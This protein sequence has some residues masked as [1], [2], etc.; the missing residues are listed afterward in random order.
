MSGQQVI[1]TSTWTRITGTNIEVIHA[2]E[3]NVAVTVRDGDTDPYLPSVAGGWRVRV[4]HGPV[5]HADSH[6]AAIAHLGFP[7][8]PAQL[9]ALLFLDSDGTLV[10]L[11][12]RQHGFPVT[13]DRRRALIAAL[14]NVALDRHNSDKDTEED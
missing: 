10:E 3:G 5:G 8:T 13:G 7:V 2:A 14:L 4:A 9:P 11:A 12:A 1:P 6:W